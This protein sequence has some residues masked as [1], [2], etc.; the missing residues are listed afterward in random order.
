MWLVLAVQMEEGL[1]E[2]LFARRRNLNIC[3]NMGVLYEI[4]NDI[5]KTSHFNTRPLLKIVENHMNRS[6]DVL[7]RYL[8]LIIEYDDT[9]QRKGDAAS[10]VKVVKEL[11]VKTCVRKIKLEEKGSS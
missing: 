9:E 7:H 4:R 3:E 10:R 8:T 5:V 1:L 6:T 2:E 11:Y